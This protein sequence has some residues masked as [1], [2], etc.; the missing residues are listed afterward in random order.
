MVRCID[1]SLYCGV[2]TDLDRR[3]GEHNS[4]SVKGAKYTRGRGPVKL[5]YF[6]EYNDKQTAMQREY[7][8][9]QWDKVKKEN[10]INQHND[11]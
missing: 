10:L 1:N 8:V 2:T 4:N 5:V 9:K 6:E 3:I 7:E 11:S